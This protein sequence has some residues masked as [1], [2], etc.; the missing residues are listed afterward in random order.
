MGLQPITIFNNLLKTAWGQHYAW[1]N[2][3]LSHACDSLALTRKWVSD[4]GASKAEQHHSSCHQK[5]QA[6]PR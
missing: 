5:W 1:I 3:A 6:Q 4:H 2:C